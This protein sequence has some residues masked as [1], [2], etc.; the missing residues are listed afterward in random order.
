M[1]GRMSKSKKSIQEKTGKQE[2]LKCQ[3]ALAATIEQEHGGGQI[4]LESAIQLQND[5]LSEAL[6]TLVAQNDIQLRLLQKQLFHSRLCAWFLGIVAAVFAVCAMILVPPVRMALV[7]V[8]QVVVTAQEAIT[9]ADQMIA[10]TQ[11][12]LDKLQ[13]VI[14]SVVNVDIA[15]TLANLNS[16]VSESRLGLQNGLQQLNEAQE[17]LLSLD[18]ATLNNTIKDFESVMKPLAALF[19]K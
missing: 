2:P 11:A 4:Q 10:S 8:N 1:L 14:T 16:L 5:R 12:S 17:K 19:G 6:G 13:P 15:G 3:E 18:I 7:G 9:T